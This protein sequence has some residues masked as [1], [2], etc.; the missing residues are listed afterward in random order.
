MNI[1]LK[2]ILDAF[3]AFVNS[4]DNTEPQK[5]ISFAFSIENLQTEVYINSLIYHYEKIFLFQSPDKKYKSIGIN[6]AII[7]QKAGTTK[8]IELNGDFNDWRE[9]LKHNWEEAGIAACPLIFCSAK[10]NPVNSSQLWTE[11][12]PIDFYVPQFIISC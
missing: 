8:F 5:L 6:S 12:D 10:F 2:N 9:H 1:N 7:F 11:F 3:D 4:I